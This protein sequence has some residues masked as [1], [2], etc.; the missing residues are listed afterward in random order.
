MGQKF[1]ISFNSA[2]RTKAHWIAWILKD[3]GHQVAVHDWEIPA[4]GNAPLWMNSKLAWADRLI[5]VV[6]PDYAPARYSPIEWASQ[7]WEDPD[8]KKG[9]VI[10]V[11]VR[12]TSEM[13]PLLR[14]LSRIDLTSCSEDEAR[15]R[16]INGMDVPAAPALKPAFERIESEPPVSEHAGPD[17]KPTFVPYVKH[18]VIFE[19]LMLAALFIGVVNTALQYKELSAGPGGAPLVLSVFFGGV[20]V[21][22]TLILLISRKGSNVAKWIFM[23]LAGLLFVNYIP[24]LADFLDRGLV[25]ILSICQTAMQAVAIYFLFT[26]ESQLWFASHARLRKIKPNAKLI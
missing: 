18:I 11:I 24:V 5:A 14:G 22:L 6:S 12:P 7:I 8:G 21:M 23:I 1:F 10:P 20:I 4:G 9:S 25:G 26:R 13:P 15:R 16:L 2:D 3:A 17:E 19:R